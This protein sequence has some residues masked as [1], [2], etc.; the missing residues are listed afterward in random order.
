MK[1]A[2]LAAAVL[3]AGAGVAWAGTGGDDDG[4]AATTSG[5]PTALAEV[6]RRDLVD[7]QDVEGAL[8]FAG[9]R[10]IAASTL[11]TLTRLR[12]EGSTVRR[13]RSLFSIDAEATAYVLYGRVPMYRTLA[14]GVSGGADVRQLERNL[15]A[16]G[17]DPY[18]AIDVDA[19][20]DSSTTAAVLRWQ[21]A[22]GATQ[23]GVLERGEIVFSDGPARVGRHEAEVGGA[24]RAGAPV[25][26]LTDRR[27]VIVARLPASRQALVRRGD[28]VR[29]TLPDGRRA[30]GRVARVG[31]V[32]TAGE[33]G[34]EATVELRVALTG[35]AG[36]RSDLDQA[37]V[38]V[39]I[40]THTA[41][42]VLA[43]P[44]TALVATAAGRYAVEVVD[45]RG[46]RRLVPVETG[47]FADGFVEVSGAGI[48][49]RLRVVVPR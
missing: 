5:V 49:E 35:R 48:R 21:A 7:R 33:E 10:K 18:D 37:P 12:P 36:R 43:V 47:A 40:A 23:D 13:G 39:S 6:T 25:I 30:G 34:A 38:T 1:R 8:A 42:G 11:G 45:A 3:A 32:A 2:A 15:V 26:E 20:W 16:L 44:V 19:T 9:S 46:T 22:R 27:R 41:E 28:R 17:H 31:R 29:V 24:A 14:S 4:G